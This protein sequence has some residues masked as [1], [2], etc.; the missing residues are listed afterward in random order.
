[1]NEILFFGV[2]FVGYIVQAISGFAGT[3]LAMPLSVKLIGMD[4]A[5]II[6]NLAGMAASIYIVAKDYSKINKKVLIYSVIWMTVGMFAAM[7]LY[8]TVDAEVLM[9]MYGIMIIAV[10][11]QKLFMKKDISVSEKYMKIVLFF[12]GIAQGLFSSGGPLVVIYLSTKIKDKVEF[13]ATVSTIWI[14]LGF[15]FIAQNASLTTGQDMKLAAFA[16]IP[17]AIGVVLGNM[18][19]HKISQEKFIKITNVLLLLSGLSVFI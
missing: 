5:R 16:M 12:S 2:V 13:R 1:M 7:V 6:L 18:I 19:H 9:Y 4:S 15:V 8:H 11:L 17:L 3:M 10:S 14:L